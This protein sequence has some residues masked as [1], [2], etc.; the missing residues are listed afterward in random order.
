M[1]KTTYSE[2]IALRALTGRVVGHEM[3]REYSK[4]AFVSVKNT[5]C[6]AIS[7]AAEASFVDRTLGRFAHFVVEKGQAD[8]VAQGIA[9]FEPEAVVLMFGGETPIEETKELFVETLRAL[10]KQD[11][12]VDIVVHVRIFAAKGLDEALKDSTIREYLGTQIVLVYT[13]DL[14]RGVLVLNEAEIDEEGGYQLD[15]LEE[16]PVTV[17][18][19]DLLNRSLRDKTVAW[20]DA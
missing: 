13:A 4:V 3:L 12:P 7:A 14:D 1:A 5:I 6:L 2:E 9:D 19:A 20:V 10:A 16:Y 17:E 15:V 18:H 8:Q 11:L